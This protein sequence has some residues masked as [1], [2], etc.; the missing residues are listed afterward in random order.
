MT[1]L[2]DDTIHTLVSLSR[3]IHLLGS[4]VRV[5]GDGVMHTH[6]SVSSLHLL[7]RGM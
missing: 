7:E 1:V 4:G 6:V 3:Y 5:L 2:D